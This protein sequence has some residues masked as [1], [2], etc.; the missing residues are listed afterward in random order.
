MGV[1]TSQRI[2]QYYEQYRSTEIIFSREIL[3]ILRVDPRQIFIK[4]SG[5]QWAC[6][7]NS[8]SL[9][10]A[11]III[12]TKGGAFAAIQKI[13]TPVSIRFY[14]VDSYGK[15]MILFVNARV[16][17]INP[18]MDSTNLAVVTLEFAGKPPDDLI[19]LLGTLLDAKTNYLRRSEERI[20]ISPE[21]MSRLSLQK[22]ESF[23]II[24]NAPRNCILRDISFRGAKALMMGNPELVKNKMTI[25]RM[26]FDDPYEVYN[27]EGKV[28]FSESIEGRQDLVSFSMQFNE[29]SIPLQYKMRINSYLVSHHKKML[30]NQAKFFAEN[31]E[32]IPEIPEDKSSEPVA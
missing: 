8:V 21:S 4:C 30:D 7:I 10:S 22:K 18:Y 9:Q 20:L 6:I 11:K 31:S 5:A 23:V 16:V 27:I 12:G 24:D 2:N 15:P 28:V 3:E 17:E 25:L 14:F 29:E 32:K 13:G 1:I 19:V 26:I